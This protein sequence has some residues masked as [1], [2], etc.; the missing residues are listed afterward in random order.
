MLC[1]AADTAAFPG[2]EG[3][4]SAKSVY[5]LQVVKCSLEPLWAKY[6][7]VFLEKQ[8]CVYDLAEGTGEKE[9]QL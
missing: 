1:F 2:T 9:D 4:I 7:L 3:L 8:V 5:V 6:I